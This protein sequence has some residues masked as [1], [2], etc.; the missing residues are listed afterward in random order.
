MVSLD[1]LCFHPNPETVA[2]P[3]PRLLECRL[4]KTT[5]MISV[6]IV[7]SKHVSLKTDSI[8]G[9]SLSF[10]GKTLVDGHLQALRSDLSATR[11]CKY[12]KAE[13]QLADCV[14]RN[15]GVLRI[16]P[17]PIGSILKASPWLYRH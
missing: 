11:E 9:D 14:T 8:A 12:L 16:D 1:A 17:R 7:M 13:Q 15:Y 5:N 10:S 3:Q 4:I 6:S 2:Q